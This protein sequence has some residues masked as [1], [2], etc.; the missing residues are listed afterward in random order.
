MRNMEEGGAKVA[1]SMIWA[2]ALIIIVGVVAGALYY[3]GILSG[4]TQKKVD[5]EISVP[6]R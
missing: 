5:V 1:S 4:K 6:S 2:I 3:G